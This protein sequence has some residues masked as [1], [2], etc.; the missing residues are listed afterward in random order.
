MRLNILSFG[1]AAFFSVSQSA[2]ADMFGADLPLLVEIVANT[3]SSLRELK[4]Q[5]DLLRR[6]LRGIDDKIRRLNA[7]KELV[8]PNN[9]DAWKDPQEA[10]RRL[11][12]IYYTLPPEFRTEKSDA[13]E[14]QITEAMRVAGLLTHAA[15]PAFRSG[16][17]LEKEAL[18]VGP[19]VSNK[20]TASGVG[21]LITLES[22]NQIAQAQIIS[23][24]SQMIAESG[25]KEVSRLNSQSREFKTMG[26]GLGGFPKQI[27][28]MEVKR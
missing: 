2:R 7:I 23:L 6:E 12:R 24:L 16:K 4:G 17:Q 1:I 13:I 27:K 11:R 18:D 8:T 3:L 15:E 28:L 25:S 21:T 19:A 10:T 14:Q 9:L 5:S 26:K 20:M 22:Q